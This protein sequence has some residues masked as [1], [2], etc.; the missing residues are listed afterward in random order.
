[1]LVDDMLN[2]LGHK[3][4]NDNKEEQSHLKE[5]EMYS[6]SLASPG[7]Y[8]LQV[9]K[10]VKEL[11]GLGLKEAKDIVD[12]A[13]NE[14]PGLYLLNDANRIKEVLEKAGA[15]VNIVSRYVQPSNSPLI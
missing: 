13:P 5:K 12:A 4:D 11:F 10:D 15:K 6:I 14:L 1:M 3:K 9:V 2:L 8:K 7:L